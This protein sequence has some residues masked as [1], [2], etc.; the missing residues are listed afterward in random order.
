MNIERGRLGRGSGRERRT[1][2]NNRVKMIE[3]YCVHV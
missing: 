2:E 3:V 1:I